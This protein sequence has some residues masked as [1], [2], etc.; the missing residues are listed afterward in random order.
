MRSGAIYAG[1]PAER[2]EKPHSLLHTLSAPPPKL[3]REYDPCRPGPLGEP[4]RALMGYE[5]RADELH[6]RGER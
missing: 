6:A 3:G 4:V 5:P 2:R 1:E